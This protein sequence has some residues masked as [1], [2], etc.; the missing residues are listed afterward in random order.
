M[1]LTTM[2]MLMRSVYSIPIERHLVGA[3]SQSEVALWLAQCS[4][5]D[6]KINM[7]VCIHN[8]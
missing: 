8:F 5:D 2:L 3:K 7:N 6:S 4:L 1:I